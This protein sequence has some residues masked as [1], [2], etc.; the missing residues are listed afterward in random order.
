MLC[1]FLSYLDIQTSTFCTTNYKSCRNHLIQHKHKASFSIYLLIPY[2][3]GKSFRNHWGKISYFDLTKE[4]FTVQI[5]RII[6]VYPLHKIKNIIHCEYCVFLF[7]YNNS[8]N[9]TRTNTSSFNWI[10]WQKSIKCDSAFLK[11]NFIYLNR[12]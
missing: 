9:E 7:S 8:H 6:A 3:N 2:L 10:I 1:H 4:I 5:L 11:D 12:Q